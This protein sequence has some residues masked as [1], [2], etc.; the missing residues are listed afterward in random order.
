MRT[1][2]CLLRTALLVFL[3]SAA[4]AV[5][6]LADNLV[7]T[8]DAGHGGAEDGAT[9]VYD[10]KLIREKDLNL[11]IANALREELLTY[12]D[13]TVYMT[14]ESDQ[15]VSLEDRTAL[16]DEH[17]S[18]LLISLHNNAEGDAQDYTSGTS[19]LISSGQYDPELAECE[20]VLGALIN[21]EL[22]SGPGTRARGLLRRLSSS[23]TYPNG[24][25]ADYYALIRDSTQRGFP[26]VIVEH[27]FL[28]DENDYRSFLSSNKK[29]RA[30]GA[31]DA[32]AIAKY[33]GLTKKDGS[34]GYDA[35]GDRIRMLSRHW[36]RKN[37]ALYYVLDDGSYKTGWFRTGDYTYYFKSS[38]AA[39]TGLLFLTG[40]DAGTYFFAENGRLLT[41]WHAGSDKKLVFHPT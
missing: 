16:A 18:D 4:S 11:A 10:G 22:H 39:A 40:E 23:S 1:V 34:V 19:V 2:S 24:A 7:V 31:A 28:D 29:L 27:S 25:L 30:L 35:A 6:A 37:G 9:A 26:S 41:S 38:G 15:T 17:E 12:E 20:A 36:M 3:L 8:I 13:V 33:F 14:R 21:E 32:T 5:S